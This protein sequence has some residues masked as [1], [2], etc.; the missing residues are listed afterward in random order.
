MTRRR[1]A[2]I[3]G[4]IAGVTAAWQLAQ[5]DRAHGGLDV[6]LFEASERL[7][8][9]VDT[10]QRDGFIIDCGPDG[11]VTEKPWACELARELGIHE[12]LIGSNDAERVTYIV[13]AG[14]LV[15]MPDGMRMMVPGNLGALDGSALFSAGAKSAY[16]AEVGRAGEL[17]AA[18][19]EQDESVAEFV[20][21]HF[22]EE[23]LRTVAAPLLSGVFG[24]D[25]AR[26]SVRAVMP[27]FVRMEREFGSL[28]LGVQA[29][30]RSRLGQKS[31]S[32]FTS[33]QGG[34]G[35]LVDRM[36]AELPP[37]W[38][39][40]S[41]AVTGLVR[42]G[43]EWQVEVEGGPD[44]FD[45]VVLAVPAHVVRE[46]LGTVSE[47]MVELLTME[48]TSAVVAAFAFAESFALPKGFGF[49]VPAGESSSLLAATFA[50]QKYAGRVP[51]GG[52]L[53]RA[54][55]GGEGV[56]M[57]EGQSDEQVAALALSELRAILGGLPV[58]SLSVVRRWPRSLPQYG[59]G[60]LER[61]AELEGLVRQQRNLWLI[62]N[63]YRGV[64]I[65]DLIRD[66]RA[67]ARELVTC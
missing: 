51:E 61:M 55:F 57:A 46:L 60:H 27:A 66:A 67:A 5:A 34:T 16:A 32:I 64:G 65:P 56:L 30:E 59:V 20:R 39:R 31:P 54:V 29:A 50:D 14:R 63:A 26:L 45:A 19:P 23:V 41:A 25:V 37:D 6:T 15:A 52:R 58:P 24:G 22:G 9:T 17:K 38:L 12:K 42:A 48:A 18:A 7:G 2:I 13:R 8:G 1:V 43:N 21:R 28:V 35:A 40:M 10:V 49:L 44:A 62:G 3:G 36:K 47:R 11:W 53:V 33:L 4:G